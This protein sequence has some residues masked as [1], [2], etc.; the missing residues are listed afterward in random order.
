[1]GKLI[2]SSDVYYNSGLTWMASRVISSLPTKCFMNLGFSILGSQ[3]TI[4]YIVLKLT[5]NFQRTKKNVKV[6]TN[7]A[8]QV[9]NVT[10]HSLSWREN[11]FPL[12][13]ILCH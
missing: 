5:I 1:M 3:G 8:Y 12:I 10:E 13:H 4:S 7:M 11:I 9:K 6:E 2:C